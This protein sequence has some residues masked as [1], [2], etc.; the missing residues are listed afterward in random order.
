[1]L[2]RRVALVLLT[3]PVAAPALAQAQRPTPEQ[4]CNPTIQKAYLAT[5]HEGDRPYQEAEITERC[6]HAHL[7]AK[8]VHD[9]ADTDP[10]ATHT[11][12]TYAAKYTGDGKLI[13]SGGFDRT[14][15]LWDAETG[16]LVRT[17]TR[18][19][20]N[21]PE[22]NPSLGFVRGLA[23]L[24]D[25][26]RVVVN[27][28]GYPLRI[29]S[30]DADEA[31]NGS[32]EPPSR[33]GV[34]GILK[35][36]DAEGPYRW[37]MSLSAKGLLFVTRRDET[38]IGALDADRFAEKYR[39]TLTF[40]K[41]VSVTVSDAAGLVATGVARESVGDRELPARIV[42]WRIE[43]GEKVAELPIDDRPTNIAFSAD[44]KVM[45]ATA[46]GGVRIF[47]VPERKQ[48]QSIRVSKF[49]VH[50]V[51]LNRDGSRLVTCAS[52]AQL[53]DVKSGKSVHHFG[54]FTDG[55][56]SVDFDPQERYLVTTSRG[57]DLRVWEVASGTFH[58][59]LG[60]NVKAKP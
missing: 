47:S 9:T 20:N 50:A 12:W 29:I 51:A 59:R 49:G 56:H 7:P 60:R 44:G 58:R 34:L 17:L 23:F 18:F 1:M 14:V 28:D 5:V 8:P 35:T 15:K 41:L 57:S 19:E 16:R 25:G 11:H 45:A 24:P 27:A 10:D 37:N 40:R 3:L 38:A 6:A 33:G 42:L 30:L 53:W 26:K 54:P 22:R 43:N 32:A 48:V 4:L 52:H 2:A 21:N 31:A 46:G 55:C 13:V 39:L 36:G